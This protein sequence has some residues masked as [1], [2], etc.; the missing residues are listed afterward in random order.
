LSADLV[1]TSAVKL[2]LAVKRARAD[3]ENIDIGSSEPIAVIGIGC[4]FPGGA[5]SPREYWQML[6]NETDTIREIPP[7]RWIAD[8]WYDADPQ[9]PGKM[10]TRWGSF[11]NDVDRFDPAFFGIA[12]REAAAMD[13]QQRLILEVTWEALWNA[14]LAPDKLAG[15]AT[16]VFTSIY[17]ADYARMLLSDPGAIGPHSCAGSSQAIASG[18]ISYLLDLHGPS[19][20]V[21]SACSS[22]LVAVHLACQSLRVGDSRMA[23]A[24]G[25]ALHLTPEHWVSLAKLGMLSPDGRCRTFDSRANG[26]VPGEGCGVVV[27]KRLVDAIADGD[28]IHAVIRGTAALQDGRSTVMTAPNGLAQQA[29]VRAALANGRVSPEQISYVET[30]GTGTALGDP[31]EVEALAEVLGGSPSCVLGSVKTNIGHLEAAAGIAGLIKAILAL[32]Y[33]QIPAN[34]HFEHPNPHFSLNETPFVIPTTVVSWPRGAAGRFAGVS[35]FGFGGTNAHVILEEAPRLPV[36]TGNKVQGPLL[37][38]I[39]ARSPEALNDLAGSYRELLATTDAVADVCR[40]AA[41]RRSHYEE[42]ISVVGSTAEELRNSLQ[43]VIAGRL[44]LGTSRG[45]AVEDTGVVFIFSGQGS[46]WAQM[47]VEL[48]RDEPVFRAAIVECDASI[49]KHGGWSL[50]TE[51]ESE[52]ATSRL[53]HTE[54]AQPAIVAIE[55]ALARLWESW[56]VVPSAVIGHSVG[57]IAAA[58]IAGALDLDEAIRIVVMRGKLMERA[59]GSGRMAAIFTSAVDVQNYIARFGNSLSIAAINGPQSVVISG[60]TPAVEAMLE[61]CRARGIGCRPLPVDYAFHSAQMEPFSDELIRRLGV[62]HAHSTAIPMIS[63]V[64]GN[65]VTGS[66][67]DAVYW[68]RNIRQPVRFSDAVSHTLT[69]EFSTLVEV[70]AHPV[71]SVSVQECIAAAEHDAV[72]LPSLRR[73]QGERSTLLTSLGAL[74]TRGATIDWPAV[75]RGPVAVVDLPAYPYQRQRYWLQSPATSALRSPA[76]LHPL[77]GH[78]IQSPL[79]SGAGFESQ[80]SLDTLPFLSDHRIGESIILPMTGFLEIVL[81]AIAETTGAATAVLE[82]VVILQPLILS[83]AGART[84]QV[85]LEGRQFRVFALDGE[86][87]ALHAT[88]QFSTTLGTSENAVP[89]VALRSALDINEHYRDAATRGAHFGPAFQTI[90]ELASSDSVATATV[91]LTT[92]EAPTA[93]SYRIHP[94]LL[95]GC[96]Q[97]ILAAV[98]NSDGPSWIPIAID[99]FELLVQAG[100]EVRSVL[101]VQARGNRGDTLAADAWITMPD[102]TPVATVSGLRL[103]RMAAEAI[104]DASRFIYTPRWHARERGKPRISSPVAGRWLLLGDEDKIVG[105]L[106]A[107]LVSCGETCVVAPA[108]VLLD[109]QQVAG[110][111]GVIHVAGANADA[112]DTRTVLRLAQFLA[113]QSGDVPALW[114]VTR[115][116]QA[117]TVNDDCAGFAQAPILGLARTIAIE[118]PELACATIDVDESSDVSRL[119][120]EILHSDGEDRIALRDSTRYVLRLEPNRASNV[121]VERRLTIPARGTIEGLQ[122]QRLE[123]RRPDAGEVEVRVE[124]SSLNFRDVMNVLGMYPGEAGELGLEFAGQIVR[125]GDG[126]SRW[127]PG[128]RVMG[129]AWGSFAT[130]VVTPATLVTAIPVGL[131]MESAA[132]I[133]NA[134][135]TAHYCLIRTARLAEGERVLIHSGAGGVG[136]AAIQIALD[137]GAEVFGTAGSDEKREYLRSIGVQH[138]LDSRS[139]NFSQQIID[140]TSGHG[141]DVVLNALSG[142]F[143]D[144]SFAAIAERG[145]FVEI[146]KIGIWSSEQVDTLDKKIEYSVIDLADVINDAP[147]V[148]GE[149][150]DRIHDLVFAGRIRP[151]PHRVFAFDDAQSAFRYM[152]QARHTGRVVLRIGTDAAAIRPDATYLITG[153]LGAIGIQVARWLASRGARHLVLLGRSAPS[154]EASVTIDEIRALGTTVMISATDVARREQVADVLRT[155]SSAMPPLRGVVHAAG[156]IDDGVLV[157][158]TWERFSAV[159][160]PKVDGALNLHELTIDASLDFFVMFSSIASVFGSPGQGAYAAG[161]AFLDS[162]AAHRRVLEMPALSVNWGAWSGSGMAARV[163]EQGRTRVLG[164]VRPMSPDDCLDA[165]EVALAR[166]EAQVIIADV[167]WQAWTGSAASL[168][169]DLVRPASAHADTLKTTQDD[170]SISGIVQQLAL[171][172]EGSRKGLLIGFVR[173]EARRVLG[174]GESHPIDERQPLLKLGL[175]SLMAV[176]LRNRLAAALGRP[177][178]ATLLFDYPS[179]AALTEFLLGGD[180]RRSEAAPDDA[181]LSDI[182][183]MS[184][185]EAERLLEQELGQI[186]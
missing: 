5:N 74:Y 7:D 181:L 175:D 125:V 32:E 60:E 179:P 15:S 83:A 99:R 113:R 129:I 139:T 29:V 177:L 167:N 94:A 76:S 67:L 101:K 91:R 16:G 150:L 110:Y 82:D 25:V 70:G 46:Q 12:P 9:A 19:V 37:L 147:S 97:A 107:G 186:G 111:R 52:V 131:D 98:G 142:E 49:Q 159:L 22:S 103:K 128:D 96:F 148:I 108:D 130:H 51:L 161:N 75:Y 145:R 54:F 122:F 40:A 31:I 172:P 71:L 1:G 164:A 10:N 69:S 115:S 14:G 144:A 106:H 119:V 149:E 39:S 44:R 50:I 152:A 33:E 57:E 38:P 184:D 68:G 136:M 117:V 81:E 114:L 2:A 61:D 3:D 102:G 30:H 56:G 185:E 176:E 154:A 153:G 48:L 141:V 163:E 42:R 93:S 132:T 79:I 137:A 143:V 134:F 85:L 88:G 95:D 156:I 23:L 157:Q 168:L 26:F 92:G 166:P 35:G 63:T 123:R 55:I 173:Q 24:G 105:Q 121:L 34:L 86:Q 17:N 64:T 80:I 104:G 100:P 183:S 20:S 182:A 112:Y 118:L 178:P 120:E 89:V 158:Q 21:D 162:L 6:L 116:A 140:L 146:G 58:H 169:S 18:R 53:E 135:L 170:A 90:V 62:V 41:L 4:R 73:N 27:L 47:G 43:E 160:A 109:L 151:L 65:P 36:P 126:V 171:A 28:R 45:R 174:L 180:S 72:V 59:T 155:I 84:V 13:P 138:V 8:D 124:A 66:D 77:L 127:T 11:V 78:R 87:W 133:P 165:F